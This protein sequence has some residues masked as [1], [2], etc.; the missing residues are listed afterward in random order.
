M[1]PSIRGVLFAF[2]HRG[3]SVVRARVLRL[4]FTVHDAGPDQRSAALR[5]YLDAQVGEDRLASFFNV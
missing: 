2:D 3:R 5:L 4:G 1:N